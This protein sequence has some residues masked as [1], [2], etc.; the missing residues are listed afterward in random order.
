MA[1]LVYTEAITRRCSMKENF[2]KC[3]GKHL[4]WS[5]FFN[6]IT[7]NFIKKLLLHRCFP[8]NFVKLSGF[9]HQTSTALYLFLSRI[10]PSRYK[11]D[12]WRV[13][14]YIFLIYFRRFWSYAVSE[15]LLVTSLLLILLYFPSLLAY[16]KCSRS[17]LF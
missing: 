2:S 14:K 7:G 9:T 13:L 8:V 3:T 10:H 16:E 1:F 12:H 15:P 5:L 17:K 6:K 4:C 11:S